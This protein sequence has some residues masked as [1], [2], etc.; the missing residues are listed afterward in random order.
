MKKFL[1]PGNIFLAKHHPQKIVG[2][3]TGTFQAIWDTG[4]SASVITQ[5][6][7]DQI[8]L[9]PIGMEINHTAMGSHNTEAY[10]IAAFLPNRVCF[11]SMRVTRGVILGFDVLIGMDIITTGDFA[12]TNLGGKTACSFR[13][14]R[15]KKSISLPRPKPRSREM[16]PALAVVGRNTSGVAAVRPF[17]ASHVPSPCALF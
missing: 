17:N 5:K 6:V 12:I 3:P 14:P 8:G 2:Q 9:K 7:I 15:A 11:P 13:F 1:V 10:L 4:A 16:L